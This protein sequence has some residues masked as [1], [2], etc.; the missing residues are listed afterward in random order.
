M[1]DRVVLYKQSGFLLHKTL[2][3]GLECGLLVDYCNVFICLLNSYSDGTHSLQRINWQT[4]DLRGM[5]YV[6]D[7]MDLLN[8]VL[9]KK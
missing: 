3:D 8:Y 2:I 6:S 9:I 1:H 7:V 5:C 4:S